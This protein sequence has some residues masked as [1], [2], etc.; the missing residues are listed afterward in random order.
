MLTCTQPI[1]WRL[2][3]LSIQT[4]RENSVRQLR[5]LRESSYVLVVPLTF[6]ILGVSVG[7]FQQKGPPSGTVVI[8]G[9]T[10]GT[11]FPEWYVWQQT[12]LSLDV[13]TSQSRIP[14]HE[15]L[16]VSEADLKVLMKEVQ[17]FRQVRSVLAKQIAETQNSLRSQGKRAGEIEAA[18][19]ALNLDY[20]YK[21]LDG[22]Q[23]IMERLSP[24]SMLGLRSWIDQRMR[25]TT[26]HLRGRAI[27]NFH[28]PWLEHREFPLS[29]VSG[30]P[31]GAS[32]PSVDRR[33]GPRR[34]RGDQRTPTL[35]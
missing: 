1:R 34:G 15:E 4:Q 14:F 30:L 29:R 3:V 19:D 2:L 9:G 21:L 11:V 6:V 20:R 18:V 5:T 13:D 24:E 26:V 35:R 16:G 23:R 7:A 12:F 17:A 25:G 33:R 32:L 8:D 10:A 31:R 27:K 22:R 28:L